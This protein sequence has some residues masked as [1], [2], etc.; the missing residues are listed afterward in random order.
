MRT[1]KVEYFRQIGTEPDPDIDTKLGEATRTELN[2]ED[3]HTVTVVLPYGQSLIYSQITDNVSNV[4]RL[5]KVR[6]VN[7]NGE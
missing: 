5:S 4:S 2:A 3:D 6:S 1:Y 7:R